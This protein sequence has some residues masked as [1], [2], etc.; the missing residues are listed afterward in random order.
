MY[1]L[2]LKLPIKNKNNIKKLNSVKLYFFKINRINNI[3]MQKMIKLLF[4]INSGS[5][6]KLVKKWKPSPLFW[7]I[8]YQGISVAVLIYPPIFLIDVKNGFGAKLTNIF[9]SMIEIYT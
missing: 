5:E 6:M 7:N 8:W 1:K 3:E 2:K 9:S 4:L